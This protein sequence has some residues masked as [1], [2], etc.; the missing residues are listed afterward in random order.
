MPEDGDYAIRYLRTVTSWTAAVLHIFNRNFLRGLDPEN[1]TI[2]IV[3]LTVSGTWT[4]PKDE[5]PPRFLMDWLGA[6]NVSKDQ[7]IQW[8]K[9]RDLDTLSRRGAVH[10]EAGLM[11]RSIEKI[12]VDCFILL[13]IPVLLFQTLLFHSRI[14]RPLWRL[15]NVAVGFAGG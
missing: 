11:A 7:V 14:I 12:P 2:R 8:M 4:L 1:M 6:R 3:F 5:E 9:T 13:F 15:Q 10:A